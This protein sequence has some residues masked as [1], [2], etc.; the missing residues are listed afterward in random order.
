MGME[1]QQTRITF[2]TTIFHLSHIFSV[3]K[4]KCGTCMIDNPN[5]VRAS[6]VSLP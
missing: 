4:A 6:V 1:N 5:K 3:T 2:D